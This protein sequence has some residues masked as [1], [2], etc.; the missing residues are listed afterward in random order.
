MSRRRHIQLS[1]SYRLWKQLFKMCTVW[2]MKR[3]KY[4]GH[5]M[6]K[7]LPKIIK[8][9]FS[10]AWTQRIVLFIISYLNFYFCLVTKNNNR[11]PITVLNKH[12]FLNVIYA[13]RCT[14]K[15][16]NKSSL[17]WRALNCKRFII[18]VHPFLSIL[19]FSVTKL[20]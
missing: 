14:I 16:N 11:F 3:W 4:I 15:C 2:N 13:L 9:A 18:R 20:N 17:M 10:M 6:Y 19:F 8:Y 5:S 7:C 12:L 1:T